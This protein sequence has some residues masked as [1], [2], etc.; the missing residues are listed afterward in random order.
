MG[1]QRPS[2]N[3]WNS[4]TTIAVSYREKPDGETIVNLVNY[5]LEPEPVQVQIKGHFSSILYE[6]PEGSCC[7]SIQPIERDGFTEFV[8]PGLIIG[9]KVHLK[10]AV[11]SPQR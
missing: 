2:L 10:P 7:Q 1:V 6:S 5:A 4:L 11:A 9:G 3:L 8:I